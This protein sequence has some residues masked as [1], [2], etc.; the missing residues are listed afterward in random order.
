[1]EPRKITVVSTRTQKKSVVMSSAETLRELKAD[2]LSSGIDYT[3]MT[4]YEGTSKTELR[5]DDS[6]LPKDV[7]YTNRTTGETI[8]TNELVFLLTNVNK[9]IAS[10]VSRAE[11][12]KEIK[13]RNLQKAC[14]DTFGKNFTQCSTASLLELLEFIKTQDSTN[15]EE[16]T[17]C[18]KEVEKKQEVKET[19]TNNHKYDSKAREAIRLLV[20]ELYDNDYISYSTMQRILSKFSVSSC[21]KS[22]EN[23]SSYS[24][25]EIDEMFADLY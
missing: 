24:D 19:S 18:E 14:I 22:N 25:S 4:F 5:S 8:I 20:E 6:I 10:G 1:M 17:V 12:Y 2:L 21:T 7:P 3:D 15:S 11:I 23:K 9:K 13:D 16:P